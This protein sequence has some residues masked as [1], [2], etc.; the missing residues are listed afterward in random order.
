MKV[1]GYV[2]VSSVSQK[3]KNNSIP[4]QRRSLKDTTFTFNVMRGYLK[5]TERTY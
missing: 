2:R 3:L 1:L 5:R 4:L